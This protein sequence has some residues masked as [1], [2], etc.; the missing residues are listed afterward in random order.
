MN[1]V[2]YVP[3]YKSP[4]SYF[5]QNGNTVPDAYVPV[6]GTEGNPAVDLYSA[7]YLHTVLVR[8]LSRCDGSGTRDDG[9]AVGRAADAPLCRFGRH[10]GVVSDAV[11]DEVPL[12]QPTVAH[13]IGGRDCGVQFY[14]Y[15]HDE[16]GYSAA[17]LFFGRCGEDTRHV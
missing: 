4:I 1:R 3:N 6:V 12:H 5:Q 8:G 15:A 10:G 14:Y 16:H 9:L 2:I 13:H 7:S 11:P 17:G